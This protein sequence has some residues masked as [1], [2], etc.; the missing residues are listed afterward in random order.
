MTNRQLQLL[1]EAIRHDKRADSVIHALQQTGMASA[2]LVSSNM[3]ILAKLNGWLLT[4]PA[5]A[6]LRALA[7]IL[8]A[9]RRRPS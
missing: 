5:T 8:L 9:L 7:A 3:T 6:I 2:Y 4:H 1:S